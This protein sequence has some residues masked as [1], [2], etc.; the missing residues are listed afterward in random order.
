VDLGGFRNVYFITHRQTCAEQADARIV[1]K[2]G[3]AVL[4]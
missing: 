1:V 4:E 2:D 3:R